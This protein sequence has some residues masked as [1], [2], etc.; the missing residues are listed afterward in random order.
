METGKI[1]MFYLQ[2][3]TG[4]DAVSQIVR[5]LE[6]NSGNENV[7]VEAQKYLNTIY[8]ELKQQDMDF[9]DYNLSRIAAKDLL[10]ETLK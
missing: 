7:K 9:R 1:D 3:A 4:T 2:I 8:D 6:T 10:E 5:I